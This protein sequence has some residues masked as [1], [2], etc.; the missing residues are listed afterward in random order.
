MDY[1]YREI[2]PQ[3]HESRSLSRISLVYL[4]IAIE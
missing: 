2:F 1:K 3:K 4:S